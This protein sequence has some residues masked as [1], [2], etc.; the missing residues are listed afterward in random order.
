[1]RMTTDRLKQCL[2]KPKVRQVIYRETLEICNTVARLIQ[3]DAEINEIYQEFKKLATVKNAFTK[4]HDFIIQAY[5]AELTGKIDLR[6]LEAYSRE[7]GV[8]WSVAGLP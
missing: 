1:M 5:D 8:L 3:N 2:Q 7:L 6:L 4:I